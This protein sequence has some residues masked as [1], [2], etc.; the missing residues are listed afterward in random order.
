MK[1]LC[2][3]LLCGLAT[4]CS[5]KKSG[6]SIYS[7]EKG[8]FSLEVPADWTVIRNDNGAQFLAPPGKGKRSVRSYLTADRYGKDRPLMLATVGPATPATL[9]GLA[10]K[11]YRWRKPL[12]QSPEFAP[13]GDSLT[14]AV[15]LERKDCVYV[16]SLVSPAS[17]G[18]RFAAQFQRSLETFWVKDRP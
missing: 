16:V 1:R 8:G 7:D 18:D 13:K 4:G 9:S 5:P 17:E 12:P 3:L 14:R 2:I 10:A 15:V 6:F 11:E